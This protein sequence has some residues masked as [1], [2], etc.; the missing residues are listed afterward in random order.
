MQAHIKELDNISLTT[1]ESVE[2]TKARCKI[3]LEEE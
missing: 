3:L 2:E 1:K